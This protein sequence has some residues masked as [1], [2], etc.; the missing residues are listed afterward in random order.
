MSHWLDETAQGLAERRLTRAGTLRLGAGVLAGTMLSSLTAPL[1]ALAA[2]GPRCGQ[3][4]LPAG[5][6][7]CKF[8]EN[9]ADGYPYDPDTHHCCTG[10]VCEQGDACCGD[11]CLSY[12]C[13][14]G[15]ACCGH[16]PSECYDPKTKVCCG[17]GKLCP[18]E[19]GGCCGGECTE[20]FC[21]NRG[22]FTRG[23]CCGE[24]ICFDPKT[25]YC[26]NDK[27]PCKKGTQCCGNRCCPPSEFGPTT[28]CGKN[29]FD[30]AREFC[31]PNKTHA[32]EHGKKCCGEKGC[33]ESGS[34][35]CCDGR[36]VRKGKCKPPPS[37]GGGGKHCPSGQV[38]CGSGK[39]A[40]CCKREYCVD[41][42]C[43]LLPCSALG[44]GW[45]CCPAGSPCP[46]CCSS[47][48]GGD[49][50]ADAPTCVGQPCY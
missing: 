21:N 47:S 25:H 5:W 17:N 8:N 40:K 10:K 41:G 39:S 9:D 26:C 35:E 42:E 3:H 4:P 11:E 23:H 6:R 22:G 28:C 1:R 2:P 44:P 15:M 27:L 31:C 46:G 32:C 38:L 20:D 18:I 29:C 14:P 12:H 37:S 43:K 45:M 13:G 30:P 36:C 19:T 16:S 49:C 7:C 48:K 33:C 34:E 50:C 24:D